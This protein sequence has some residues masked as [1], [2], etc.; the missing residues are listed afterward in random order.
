MGFSSFVTEPTHWESSGTGYKITHA[1][2]HF[3]P[4]WVKY[5]I[6]LVYR[7]KMS[8]IPESVSNVQVSYALLQPISYE[9]Q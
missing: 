8:G 5:S 7:L 1:A 3:I 6:Y 4:S 2:L 9:N